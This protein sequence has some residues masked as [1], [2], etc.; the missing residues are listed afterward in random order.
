MAR[1]APA[2]PA[3]RR[4]LDPA[5]EAARRTSLSIVWRRAAASVLWPHSAA[6]EMDARA[7]EMIELFAIGGSLADA[8]STSSGRPQTRSPCR[9]GRWYPAA[10]WHRQRLG[11]GPGGKLKE[12]THT[13]KG[14][15]RATKVKS[16]RLCECGQC[17]A[18]GPRLLQS[19]QIQLVIMSDQS[20]NVCVK[21]GL[22]LLADGASLSPTSAA[23]ADSAPAAPRPS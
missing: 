7:G 15:K 17:L 16:R 2:A 4:S 11:S 5:A 20:V 8:A 18:A 3:T 12:R 19:N 6:L 9:A 22:F 1:Y 21:L 13:R 14:G 23:A 10:A